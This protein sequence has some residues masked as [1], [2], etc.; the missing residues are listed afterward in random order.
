MRKLKGITINGEWLGDNVLI[1]AN[2]RAICNLAPFVMQEFAKLVNSI[3]KLDSAVAI[4][5]F[6]FPDNNTID[7]E[8]SNNSFSGLANL[9]FHLQHGLPELVNRSLTIYTD[10]PEKEA[11]ASE[12][13]LDKIPENQEVEMANEYVEDIEKEDDV[14]EIPSEET[15]EYSNKVLTE[16]EETEEATETTE[17]TDAAE[18]ETAVSEENEK[19]SDRDTPVNTQNAISMM[20][21]DLAA[22]SPALAPIQIQ[23][24]QTAP[25]DTP[26]A[27]EIKQDL[28]TQEEVMNET[29]TE[30]KLT[31]ATVTTAEAEAEAE[32]A[33]AA[34]AEEE[35]EEEEEVSESIAN[36]E[37]KNEE[38]ELQNSE[39]IDNFINKKTEDNSIEY[40]ND[41]ISS[42]LELNSKP[43]NCTDNTTIEDNNEILEKDN[44]ENISL[45]AQLE[46][47]LEVAQDENIIENGIETK[48]P[49]I[50][51]E[52]KEEIQ[53]C[54][55]D[56]YDSTPT[57]TIEQIEL[58][59][60]DNLAMQAMLNEMFVLRDEL[61]KL[62]NEKVTYEDI[63]GKKEKMK[64][65]IED[66]DAD[67][68]IM[69]SEERVNASILDEELFVAGDKLYKWGDTLYLDE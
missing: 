47:E 11:E 59:G 17:F 27:E 33:T 49:E 3:D 10:N 57:P 12:E 32:A 54:L 44:N 7:I 35:E 34:A 67:F 29:E 19:I 50:S 62:K 43:E 66:E 41:E 39:N 8:F 48:E 28:V 60:A 38:A 56:F 61:N 2:F 21:E 30:D 15:N 69:G 9:C 16:L 25:L 68:R 46:T 55:S 52:Q 6:Y 13:N 20:V 45:D 63:F 51:E 5:S 37:I 14:Y 1:N 65:N 31:T 36:I 58:K 42:E 22:K 64:N 18:T 40:T 26:K 53:D 4:N 24:I 23:V